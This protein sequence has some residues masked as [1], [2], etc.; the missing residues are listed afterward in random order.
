M[1]KVQKSVVPGS[2]EERTLGE[3]V[4]LWYHFSAM[5]EVQNQVSDLEIPAS[6][7]RSEDLSSQKLESR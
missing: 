1:S 4:L 2:R 5:Q 6:S 3:V 7:V